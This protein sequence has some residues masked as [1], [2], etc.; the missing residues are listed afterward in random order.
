MSLACILHH[1]A[2]QTLLSPEASDSPLTLNSG[3]KACSVYKRIRVGTQQSLKS[4]QVPCPIASYWLALG[5]P[6]ARCPPSSPCSPSSPLLLSLLLLASAFSHWSGTICCFHMS[7]KLKKEFLHGKFL[8]VGKTHFNKKNYECSLSSWSYF[9]LQSQ[10]FLFVAVMVLGTN[11]RICCS[12]VRKK[13]ISKHFYMYL[14][15]LIY[16]VFYFQ[17]P[18]P[19]KFVKTPILTVSRVPS[20]KLQEQLKSQTNW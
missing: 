9:V 12:K 10:F 15:R 14:C 2:A 16:I 11:I 19:E 17:I 3:D 7:W 6:L 18:I 20:E 8:F 13:Y 1:H 5:S 4:Q